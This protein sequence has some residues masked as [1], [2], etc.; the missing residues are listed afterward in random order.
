M[1]RYLLYPS[2]LILLA[3]NM[4]PLVGVL[5]WGWDA[6]VL[7]VLYWL[8]TAVI[9][10]W[11]IVRIATTPRDSLGD[12]K[13]NGSDKPGA[14]LGLALFFTVHA[15]IFMAVHFLFLWTL[16]SGGWARKIHSP[17][18]F[19]DQIVIGTGLWL[20]LVVLFLVR[21]WLIMF[22]RFEPGLRRT[23]R[24]APRRPAPAS[25]LTSTESS[26]FGLYARI[27]IMQ[28]TILLGAWVALLV[29]AA[30]AYALLVLLKTALD[31]AF[32]VNGDRIYVAL[33]EKA[34]DASPST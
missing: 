19:F 6:F 25:L 11:T 23:F 5:A 34:K 33:K 13:F 28:F 7:L 10:F 29:G 30:G 1:A 4:F 27:F 32:Q 18:E 9:A 17:G 15:G 24:I 14:P 20:P 12:I 8:E 3:A 31:V 22:E 16:F 2:T 26:L 21:G